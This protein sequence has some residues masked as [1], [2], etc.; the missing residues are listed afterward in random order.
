[1]NERTIG[2]VT[3]RAT[4]AALRPQCHAHRAYLRWATQRPARAC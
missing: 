4:S 1:M 2:A 3:A